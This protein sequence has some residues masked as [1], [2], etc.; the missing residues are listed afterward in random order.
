MAN[1][2]IAKFLTSAKTVISIIVIIVALVVWFVALRDDVESN[3]KQLEIVCPKAQENREK[4]IGIE[5]DVK[6]TK[7]TVD[8]IWEKVK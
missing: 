6:H 1:N 7:E 8:R 3:T 5:K 4:I 2:G